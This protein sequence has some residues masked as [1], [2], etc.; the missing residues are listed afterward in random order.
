MRIGR[1]TVGRC[2]HILLTSGSVT[3]SSFERPGYV[4]GIAEP[5]EKFRFDQGCTYVILSR[6][7]LERVEIIHLALLL[8]GQVQAFPSKLYVLRRGSEPQSQHHD[9]I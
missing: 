4:D 5:D 6:W 7:N 2:N 8:L 1:H 9:Q 3:D